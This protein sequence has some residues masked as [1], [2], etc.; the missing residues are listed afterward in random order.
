MGKRAV[1]LVSLRPR[2]PQPACRNSS[3]AMDRTRAR[4]GLGG[5]RRNRSNSFRYA[6]QRT[7]GITHRLLSGGV[8]CCMEPDNSMCACIE[9]VVPAPFHY[10]SWV[11]P[12]QIEFQFQFNKAPTPDIE[13]RAPFESSPRWPMQ[14]HGPSPRFGVLHT[15]RRTGEVPIGGACLGATPLED[16]PNWTCVIVPRPGLMNPTRQPGSR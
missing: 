11:R 13:R 7:G 1:R 4:A 8:C 15:I 10:P 6:L 9:H 16:D 2:C 3:V 5:R 12:G 14:V